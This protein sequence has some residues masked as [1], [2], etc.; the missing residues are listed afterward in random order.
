MSEVHQ[1]GGHE[2]RTLS[3]ELQ[4]MWRMENR[5]DTKNQS[6]EE[7][8][9]HRKKM[10]EQLEA[11]SEADKTALRDRLQ[12]KWD[13]LPADEKKKIAEKVAKIGEGKGPKGKKEKGN[14]KRKGKKVAGSTG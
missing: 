11:L 7:K 6:K 4:V 3:P 13:A 8:Q 12:A 1:S 2:G 9:Q 10:R 14:V 5:G